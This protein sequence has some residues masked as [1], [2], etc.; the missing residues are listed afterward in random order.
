MRAGRR[1]DI[2]RELPALLNHDFVRFFAVD[3]PRSEKLA[4]RI[5]SA[6]GFTR[7]SGLSADT[8]ISEIR[9]GGEVEEL[10]PGTGRRG[11]DARA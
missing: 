9:A 3:G 5:D 4:I 6:P 7:R 1:D 11:Q 10:P 8:L 2:C